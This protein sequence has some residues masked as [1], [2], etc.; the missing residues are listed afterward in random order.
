MLTLELEAVQTRIVARLLANGFEMARSPALNPGSMWNFEGPLEL[1]KGP[2]SIRIQLD[3]DSNAQVPTAGPLRV[4]FH[5]LDL[6]GMRDTVGHE[7]PKKARAMAT[8]L[9]GRPSAE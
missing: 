8:L 1:L 5:R 7:F 2:N 6:F 3:P 4:R 9:E